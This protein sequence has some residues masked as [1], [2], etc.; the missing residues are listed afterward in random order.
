MTTLSFTCAGCGTVVPATGS[1]S[2]PFRCPS[3]RP[4]DDIDHVV[5]RTFDPAG[6]TF[7]DPD[8]PNPFIRY[9]HLLS[10]H[11]LALDSSLSDETFVKIVRELDAAVGRV[12][13]KGFSER[14]FS[15]AAALGQ[16]LECGKG[17]VWV[18]DETG[19][20][21]GSHKAR[22]LMGVMLYLLVMESITRQS[23][24]GRSPLAIAS[25]GNAALAAAVVARAADWPLQVFV[26]SSAPGS[27]VARL[28]QLGGQVRV[29]DRQEGL[30]GD[31]SYH[32]FRDALAAGAIPFSCQGSDNGL[33]IEGGETLAWEMISANRRLV[34]AT[35]Q[36]GAR[37]L[38]AVFIQVGGGA[39]A[40]AVMQGFA[41]AKQI[42]VVD[43][44]PRF[45]TVQ[46]R[47]G[48]P[49]KRAYDRIAERILARVPLVIDQGFSPAADQ[50]RADLIASHPAL[51]DEEMQYART[52]RSAFM[53][54]WE[55]APQSIAHGILD[56]ETYDWAAVVEG[57]LRTA[58]WPLVVGEERL[59]DANAIARET[60]GIDVD[61]TGSAGLAGLMKAMSTDRRLADERVAVIFSGVNR[62]ADPKADA[63]AAAVARDGR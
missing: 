6:R 51:I 45:Y 27:I 61:H 1:G 8:E 9:R 10:A 32:A 2:Y 38:N 7:P 13:G 16:R 39:L 11:A 35:R 21:S 57:M 55:K 43:R 20:V 59:I 52:H 53:A 30:P 54:P 44:L 47:G 36:W 62:G 31:P 25:C 12:D 23:R 63:T 56:D 14:P 37:R 24:D 4:G 34:A 28:Q 3:A 46:T 60:T 33:T 17:E 18:M 50:E 40:S 19:N 49:L 5:R 22:H 29:C 58:G 26:P 41:E 48:Y 42:G 15:L